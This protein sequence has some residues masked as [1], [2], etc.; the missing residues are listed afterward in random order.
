MFVMNVSCD[1]TNE[2]PTKLSAPIQLIVY[3][4]EPCESVNK[5]DLD[6]LSLNFFCQYIII[7][8]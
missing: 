2:V 4:E 7:L 3:E 8:I 1:Q 5:S 6:Q